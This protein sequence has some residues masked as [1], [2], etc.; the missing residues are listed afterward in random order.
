MAWA[1]G[2]EMLASGVFLIWLIAHATWSKSNT[3]IA[4]SLLAGLA[5]LGYGGALAIR[6]IAWNVSPR[7]RGALGIALLALLATPLAWGLW[8]VAERAA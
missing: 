3:G 1:L 2:V 5:A 4:L 6:A 8:R 7:L